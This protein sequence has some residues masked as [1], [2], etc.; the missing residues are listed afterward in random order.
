[1][2]TKINKDP[3]QV[4]T[5]GHSWDGIEELNNPLPSWW[6]WSFYGCI[7][8]ALV[9]SILYPAWPLLDK[10]TPGILGYSTRAE[11]A[12]DIQKFE[13]ANAN[14]VSRLETIDL[15][16]A[17]IRADEDLYNYAVQGGA[18]VFRTWCAQCHGS[19]AAGVQASG[20]P[21]L[22][23]DDWLWGGALEDIHYT[24][25]N[26]IR[27]EDN[28]D[29]RWSQMPAFGADELLSNEEIG[30]VVQYVLKISGQEH[31]AALATPG[32]T[33][34]LD[35][36]AACHMD[37]GTGDRYQGA[38]NLTDAIWLYGGDAETLT[39]TVKNARFGVMPTHVERLSEAERRAVAVYVHTRG[40]GE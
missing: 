29:A 11:V 9:Y 16:M 7:L 30:Q 32:E 35:N 20:Y 22:T 12:K 21:N 5:T 36:C 33:V 31:D 34:F 4:E 25:T 10:A 2:S 27:N 40:G 23:D 17:T 6:L 15:D 1:M 37:D 13:D 28:P 26:G 38:P 19:G 18:A 14:L 3:D 8:F 24:V 39:E